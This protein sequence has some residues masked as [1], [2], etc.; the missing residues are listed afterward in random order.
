MSYPLKTRRRAFGLARPFLGISLHSATLRSRS[1]EK[2]GI[3]FLR[4]NPHRE[5]EF[6][7]ASEMVQT[8][9]S[10][11]PSFSP[12][13]ILPPMY[14]SESDSEKG[15]SSSTVFTGRRSL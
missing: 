8:Y 5:K 14:P 15:Y 12:F 11:P 2:S 3:F 10:S 7:N 9:P 13:L 4:F 1:M 6:L